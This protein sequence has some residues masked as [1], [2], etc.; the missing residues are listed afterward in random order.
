MVERAARTR[1]ATP[2]TYPFIER[3]QWSIRDGG[4]AM[5]LRFLGRCALTGLLSLLLA[6]AAFS[7]SASV[8]REMSANDLAR[9]VVAN[10]LKSQDANHDRWMYHV[11]REEQGK[12]RAKEVVQTGQVRSTD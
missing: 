11:D 5:S 9:A 4:E 2:G 10:E 7:Q 1:A 6:V 12:K 8:D 3:Q